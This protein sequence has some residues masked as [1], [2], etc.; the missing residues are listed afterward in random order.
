MNETDEPS[1]EDKTRHEPPKT[2]GDENASVALPVTLGDR[3][4]ITYPEGLD[5]DIRTKGNP[6]VFH[7]GGCR[8]D[9]IILHSPD[10]HERSVEN[11]AIYGPDGRTIEGVYRFNERLLVHAKTVR[12]DH[13][14]VPMLD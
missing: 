7:Y 5:A 9:G 14:D 4:E 6:E 11:D 3:I 2:R 13:I 10:E 12:V 8:R 1:Q